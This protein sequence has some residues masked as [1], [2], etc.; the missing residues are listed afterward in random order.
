MEEERTNDSFKT[1]PVELKGVEFS[2]INSNLGHSYL[3]ALF[4]SENIELY[5]SDVNYMIIEYLY[6]YHRYQVV[7][8]STPELFL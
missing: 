3:N 4:N 6:K 7:L 5:G 8:Y 2:W 1:F